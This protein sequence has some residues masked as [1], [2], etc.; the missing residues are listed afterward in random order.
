MGG[1]IVGQRGDPPLRPGCSGG[2][3]AALGRCPNG[4]PRRRVTPA[5]EA[6]HARLRAMRGRPRPRPPPASRGSPHSTG[7]PR[8]PIC[9][10]RP[11]SSKASVS[12]AMAPS[13]RWTR[14]SVTTSPGPTTFRRLEQGLPQRL[15][16]PGLVAVLPEECRQGRSGSPAAGPGSQVG[17]QGRLLPGRGVCAL[18]KAV[19]SGCSERVQVQ[20]DPTATP[21]K[22]DG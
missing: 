5:A 4:L 14:R 9:S 8:H 21:R 20:H 16:S 7:S 18:G 3:L 15:A 12:V 17:E 10:R 13:A 22:R 11:P 19:Q 1:R 2:P 6:A